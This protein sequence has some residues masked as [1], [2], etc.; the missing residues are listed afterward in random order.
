MF[1]KILPLALLFSCNAP[2]KA[3]SFI[4]G[5]SSEAI[6]NF[7]I[8]N[9]K[10]KI[11]ARTWGLA[12]NH[13]EISVFQINEINPDGIIIKQTFYTDELFYRKRGLDTL[14]IFAPGSSYNKEFL[15]RIGNVTLDIHPLKT[16]AQVLEL[17]SKYKEMGL[18]RISVY[19]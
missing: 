12:G 7:A 17:N 13:E 16:N 18:H 19:D 10:I 9:Q 5:N 3:N 14:Q 2:D 15:H 8:V 6:L 4:G 11:K 1:F